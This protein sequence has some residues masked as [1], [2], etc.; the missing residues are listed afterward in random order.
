MWRIFKK[1]KG[2]NNFWL[3]VCDMGQLCKTEFISAANE[4][5]FS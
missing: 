1:V 5:E 2:K 4:R 3:V